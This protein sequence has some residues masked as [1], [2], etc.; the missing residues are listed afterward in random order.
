M[1]NTPSRTKTTTKARGKKTA[2]VKFNKAKYRKLV[3]DALP[4]VVETEAENERLLAIIQP[5]MSRE[6]TP[7]EEMLFDLLVRLVADFEERHYPDRKSTRL[8][9]SHLGI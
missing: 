9:S 4:A 8:N 6:L 3:A 2:A 7:E 5:M 1:L